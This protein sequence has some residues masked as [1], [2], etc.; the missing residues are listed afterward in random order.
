MQSAVLRFDKHCSTGREFWMRQ[1]PESIDFRTKTL[2]VFF[3]TLASFE[4]P[5]RELGIRNMQDVNVINE[6][7]LTDIEKVLQN[8]RTF[9]LSIVTEHND[10][11][12][13]HDLEF[14]EPHNFFAQLPSMWLK[15]SASSLEHLTLSCD[16]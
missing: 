10:A 14:P 13:E 4:A 8:L 11:A 15:P 3:R 9:R 12:P 6:K 5:L 2:G 7:I 16:N 1:S